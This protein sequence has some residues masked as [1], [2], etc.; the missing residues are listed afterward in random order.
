MTVIFYICD[1]GK[2]MQKPNCAVCWKK[3]CIN[4]GKR[5]C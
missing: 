3:D 4:K 2:F 5:Q 1:A